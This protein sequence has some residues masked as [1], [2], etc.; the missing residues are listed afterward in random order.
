MWII[1]QEDYLKKGNK[2]NIEK[3][4]RRAMAHKGVRKQLALANISGVDVMTISN[5]IN[6]KPTSLAT[7]K[8]IA[9]ALD[10]SVSEFIK[11]GEEL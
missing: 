4:I 11:L 1:I 2:M 10:Y 3:S 8:K 9:D 6:N 7:V 5:A